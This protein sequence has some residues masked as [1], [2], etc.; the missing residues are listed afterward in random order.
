MQG[1]AEIYP[2][3]PLQY[4]KNLI[5]VGNPSTGPSQIQ[6]CQMS[7]GVLF[8]RI[9]HLNNGADSPD[10]AAVMRDCKDICCN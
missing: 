10:V 2:L 4:K 7:K 3:D 8:V 9:C 5:N 6:V 1:S